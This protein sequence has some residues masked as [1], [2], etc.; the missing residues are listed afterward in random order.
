MRYSLSH[1]VTI[2][3][4]YIVER[5]LFVGV[6]TQRVREGG[7]ESRPA[8]RLV[9]VVM[10]TPGTTGLNSTTTDIKPGALALLTPP[11]EALAR[12]HPGRSEWTR[13]RSGEAQSIP[14]DDPAASAQL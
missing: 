13:G 9:V 7:V 11:G 4:L 12:H 8:L 10:A 3:M 14:H 2:V 1:P 5:E 6:S